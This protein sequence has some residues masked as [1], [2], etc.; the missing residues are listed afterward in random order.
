LVAHQAVVTPASS[1]KV[2]TLREF[3][4]DFLRFMGYRAWGAGALLVLGALV[5]GIG[6]L[7]LLPIL[8]VVLGAGS[9]SGWIADF[10]RELVA[11]IPA[12][13]PFW[14]LA[15]LLALFAVLLAIRS[16]IMIKRDVTLARLQIGFVESHRLQIIRLIANTLWDVISR[17]KHGRVTHV[18]GGDIQECGNAAYLGLQ[19]AVNLA[20][21]AGQTLLVLFLSP[22][23]ALIVVLLL[24]GGALALRPVLRRSRAL[25]AQLTE[26]NLALVTSTTQFLGGLKL[27]LSQN[28][29]RSFV[30]EFEETLGHAGSRRVAF[31]RQRTRAQLALTSTAAL[32]GGVAMLVGIG[33]LDA[34]PTAL[35]AFLFVLARM[36]GPVM[37]IQGAAQQIF[38][39]LPAYRKIKELEAELGRQ[40]NPERPKAPTAAR[41]EGRVT[42]DDVGFTHREWSDGEGAGGVR[43]LSLTIKQ[44]SFVGVT[45]A[46]GA[47]KTTFADLLVG[48]YPPQAGSIRVAGKSL[49]GEH[50][51][52]W[53]ESVSYVSQDPF[54]FHDTVRRNLL[55]A[56]PDAGEEDLW[57]ALRRASAEA[58]VRRMP[59]G[60][61]TLVGERGT[62]IS[63]GERQRIALARALL[64][65]P[66]LLLLD[67]ATNAIDVE[68]EQVILSGLREA[69]DR[70]TIVMIAHREA[71]LRLCERLIH[72]SDGKAAAA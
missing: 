55:W 70:P 46:S 59:L 67:E 33:L 64:R 15:F 34:S 51:L 40:Q 58:I 23:L 48:L 5:E 69:A 47:G 66:S 10:S 8:T 12:A 22:A 36:N 71:S 9:S 43:E 14:Q 29:Q 60:L 39:S 11:F 63:G 54:L 35:I 28:L 41:I 52:A 62:L 42:F 49:E 7:L 31:T 50:L 27:A 18:L 25:G 3:A 6:L 56:R 44:G 13:T 2:G 32:V 65:R 4:G 21:L 38:H 30:A 37:A 19:C 17:L 57:A 24:A 20:M 1:H 53:R 45:G 72:F 68:G 16:L 26:S 61:E